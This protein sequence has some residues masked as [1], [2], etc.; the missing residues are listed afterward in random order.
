MHTRR[1][2]RAAS[3]NT[4]TTD[5]SAWR[6]GARINQT[7]ATLDGNIGVGSARIQRNTED[8]R[9]SATFIRTNT[10]RRGASR[11]RYWA[12]IH[13][14]A[15]GFPGIKIGARIINGYI[16]NRISGIRTNA[17]CSIDFASGQ[18]TSRAA[19]YIRNRHISIRWINHNSHRAI[20]DWRGTRQ[21][22][23]ITSV[24][25]QCA[26]I[27]IVTAGNIGILSRRINRNALCCTSF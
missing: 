9:C 6:G 1:K 3:T 21:A 4:G 23:L 5:C 8:F 7:C 12:R 10:N 16:S 20:Q 14:G 11:Y 19:A 13:K 26:F 24:P 15:S 27:N 22:Y 18:R 17:S 2:T 25:P